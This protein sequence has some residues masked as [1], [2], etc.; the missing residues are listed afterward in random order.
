[1]FAY[2]PLV[3]EGGEKKLSGQM[4]LDRPFS[5]TPFDSLNVPNY[6]QLRH[7]PHLM[8]CIMNA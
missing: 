1:M 6:T 4:S 7:P 8:C 5:K 2:F 3:F